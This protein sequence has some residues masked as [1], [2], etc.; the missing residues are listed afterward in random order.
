MDVHQLFYSVKMNQTWF[1]ENRDIFLIRFSL[2]V[3]FILARYDANVF[4][5]AYLNYPFFPWNICAISE[6][7]PHVRFFPC[8][9][10]DGKWQ[11]EPYSEKRMSLGHFA[12]SHDIS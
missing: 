5:T 9:L 12:T 10:S 11:A 6:K 4:P 8:T 3:P 7:M 2:V 1:S